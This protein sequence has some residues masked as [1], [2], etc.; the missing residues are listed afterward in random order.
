MFI[1]EISFI[2]INFPYQRK[3]GTAFKIFPAPAGSWWPLVQNIPY[4]KNI[5]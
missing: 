2:N 4:V 5:F 3:T 1:Y